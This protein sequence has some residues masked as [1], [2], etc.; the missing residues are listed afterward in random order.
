[1]RT[2]VKIAVVVA[3]CLV[4]LFVAWYFVFYQH[5]EQPS[6][7]EL[8]RGRASETE[9]VNLVPAGEAGGQP[10]AEPAIAT[11]TAPEAEP[12]P[13]PTPAPA[14][15][16]ITPQ[17]QEG[18]ATPGE[19]AA[20]PTPSP[21]TPAVGAEVPPAPAEARLP[22]VTGL[23][24]AASAT[25][26]EEPALPAGPQ[27]RYVVKKGDTYWEIA[28]REYGNGAL[29]KL[30]Q[31][32]NPN[33]PPTKLRPGTTIVLPPRPAT[34]A[35][36]PAAGAASTAAAGTLATD[37]ATGK[38][39]YVVKPGD[40]GFWTVAKV[41]YG[42]SAYYRLIAEANPDL[43][44]R[45]LKPGDRVWVPERPAGAPGPVPAAA[46]PAEAAVPAGPAGRTVG[47][48]EVI[49]GAPVTAKLPDGTLFD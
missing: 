21:A 1:M 2:E 38:R 25:V 23:M 18:P 42:S 27:R 20:V 13:M 9:E 6:G 15:G 17:Y 7:R 34:A 35:G 49:T 32:A 14:A 4:L 12:T 24:P 40:R 37:P 28:E 8:A 47:G 48:V 33:I 31:D 5:E 29:Y 10:G 45:A 19:T 3:A 36:A 16:L 41:A 44:P 39:Y 11:P 46:G 22:D 43:D 26:A 30:I